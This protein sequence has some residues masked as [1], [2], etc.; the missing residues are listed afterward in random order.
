VGADRLR[1][2]ERVVAGAAQHPDERRAAGKAF[3]ATLEL[4]ARRDG[5]SVLIEIADDGKGIDWSKV[6][7]LARER[8]L[9]SNSRADLTEALFATALSTRDELSETSGRGMGL[10]AVRREIRALGGSIEV[11]SERGR[12][13]RFKLRVPSAALGVHPPAPKR[14]GSASRPP[15]APEQHSVGD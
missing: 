7:E 1:A 15:P 5:S 2:R 6:Q 4:G 13:C 9:A 10:D 3:P 8:G 11:E 14:S 12:G